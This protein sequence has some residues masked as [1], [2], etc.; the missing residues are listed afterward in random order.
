MSLSNMAQNQ[1]ISHFCGLPVTV[2]RKSLLITIV[3]KAPPLG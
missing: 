2:A 3:T 1:L